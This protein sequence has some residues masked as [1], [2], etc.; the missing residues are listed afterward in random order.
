MIVPGHTLS[1]CLST[2]EQALG[3]PA[4]QAMYLQGQSL[5]Y[6]ISAQICIVQGLDFGV[7]CSLTKLYSTLC[8]PM[9]CS[10]QGLSAHE[11]FL[12]SILEWV[13]IVLLHV[14]CSSAGKESTCDAGSIPGLGRYPREGM[15]YLLQY[16]WASLLQ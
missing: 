6:G 8:D 3:L 15:G 5:H 16:F 7:L 14:A 1:L 2:Q 12:A 11:I 9:D 4:L 10:P 13:A